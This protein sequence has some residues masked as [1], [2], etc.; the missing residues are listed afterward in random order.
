MLRHSNII[1][2]QKQVPTARHQMQAPSQPPNPPQWQGDVRARI[3]KLLR[4]PDIDSKESIPPAYA[5]RRAGR[6][7]NPIPNWFLAPIDCSK[8][9]AQVKEP[10]PPPRPPSL[11]RCIPKCGKL[12]GQKGQE[13]IPSLGQDVTPR[14][15]LSQMGPLLHPCPTP[16]PPRVKGR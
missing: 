11:P 10:P 16:P 9:P 2:K 5:A 12:R 1:Q 14:T 8:I 7:D 13:A 3:F 4:H 6:Y 15:Y